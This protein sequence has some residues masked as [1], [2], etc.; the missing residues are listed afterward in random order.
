MTDQIVQSVIEWVGSVPVITIYLIFLGVAYF[1]N[2]IPPMPGDVLVAFSGYLAAE[3][4]ILLLPVW[5][6][7]TIASVFGFMTMYWLGGRWSY[8]IAHQKKD[9]WLLRFI[10]FSYFETGKRWMDRWGQGV[11]LANRFLAGTRSIIS[12]TAGFYKLNP[13][14]TIVSSFVS[15]AIWNSI[16]IAFGWI[17]KSNWQS[18][19]YYLT[20]YSKIILIGIAIL[21]LFRVFLWYR[22]RQKISARKGEDSR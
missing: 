15:S 5:L 19:Q 3:G 21:I 10:D 12:L 20:T 11:V 22:R 13:R 9:H 1:E 16:L 8:D 17:V 4:L 18:V 2:L 14:I 7:T 6:I